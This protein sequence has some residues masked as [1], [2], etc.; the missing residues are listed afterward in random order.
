MT[1]LSSET[2]DDALQGLGAPMSNITAVTSGVFS[3][4]TE[5][6]AEEEADRSMDVC[7]WLNPEEE[8]K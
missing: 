5:S 6:S 4:I 1:T 8:R 2:S 3:A 7:D